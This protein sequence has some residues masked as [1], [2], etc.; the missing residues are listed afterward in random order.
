MMPRLV[1][2]PLDIFFEEIEDE[3]VYLRE[4]EKLTQAEEDPVGQWLKLA[5][6]RG[7]TGDS[8]TVLLT[9]VAELHRKIDDLNAYVR[10]EIPKRLELAKKALVDSIGFEHINLQEEIL[11]PQK[12]YYARILMPI[13]PKREIALFL[14]AKS[15]TLVE[16]TRMHE[17]DSKDWDAYIMARERIMIRQKK[18]ENDRF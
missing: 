15:T 14:E 10:N 9:L 18:A 17:S 2:A 13:F 1:Q 6:A 8:D 12:R 16:I 3:E 7:E 11:E 5:K 4:F